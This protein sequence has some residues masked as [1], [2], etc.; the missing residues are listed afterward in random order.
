MAWLYVEFS[1]EKSTNADLLPTNI[2]SG[3]ASA[4]G[5]IRTIN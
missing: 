2:I 4:A 5:I 1:K 3:D